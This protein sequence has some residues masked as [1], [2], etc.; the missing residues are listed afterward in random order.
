MSDIVNVNIDELKTIATT[1]KAK[2]EE[3]YS[4]YKGEFS[5]I[6]EDSKSC[7][8]VSGLDFGSMQSSFNTLFTNL[9]T[10]LTNLS[11]VLTN[12][13]IPNYENGAESLKNMFNSDFASAMQDILGEINK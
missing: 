7:I 11:E 3:L 4:L 12:K 5:S 8:K 13:V 1:L 10:Q 2:N 9:N 6:L